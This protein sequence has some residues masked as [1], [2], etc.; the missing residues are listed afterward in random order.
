MHVSHGKFSQ[1]VAKRLLQSLLQFSG[2]SL[3]IGEATEG[4]WIYSMFP[5]IFF[6]TDQFTVELQWLE[7]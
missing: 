1:D 6:Q 2:Q 4:V 5:T 7:F 3:K